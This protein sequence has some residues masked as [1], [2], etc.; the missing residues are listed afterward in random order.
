[1]IELKQLCGLG[2]ERFLEEI[3]PLSETPALPYWPSDKR[4][5]LTSLSIK[6]G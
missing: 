5:V 4:W 6:W 2:R 3:L 1:M